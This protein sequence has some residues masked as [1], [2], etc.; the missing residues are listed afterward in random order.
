MERKVYRN[1]VP[2]NKKGPRKPVKKIDW[3]NKLKYPIQ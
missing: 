1:I 2:N 3:N